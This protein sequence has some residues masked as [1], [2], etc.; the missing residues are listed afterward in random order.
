MKKLQEML[1]IADIHADRIRLA[2]T[3]IKHIFPVNAKYIEKI[4]DNELAWAELLIS[5]FEKLQDFIGGKIIDAFFE[6]QEEIVSDF[7][8]IDKLNKL[9]RLGIIEDIEVWRKMREVRN[10]LAHEYP[11]HPEIAADYLNQLVDLVPELL[12]VLNNIKNKSV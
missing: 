1:K 11:E 4:P 12:R 7:T 3:K 10:H 5:R 9:E 2:M 8:M 6:D